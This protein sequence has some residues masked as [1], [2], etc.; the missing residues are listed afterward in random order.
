M[1]KPRATLRT[2]DAASTAT[3]RAQQTQPHSSPTTAA[4]MMSSAVPKLV[5]AIPRMAAADPPSEDRENETKW[6]VVT[7]RNAI[8]NGQAVAPNTSG[9]AM[10]ITR[11]H[12]IASNIGNRVEVVVGDTLF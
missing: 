4:A 3:A 5:G 2:T 1:L 9:T 11:K 8:A 10:A 12:V 6:I 7:S